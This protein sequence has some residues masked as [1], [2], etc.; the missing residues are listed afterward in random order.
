MFDPQDLHANAA[1]SP[2]RKQ[3]FSSEVKGILRALDLDLI[4]PKRKQIEDLRLHVD[5]AVRASEFLP[6][7]INQEIIELEHQVSS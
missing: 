1:P 6:V 4:S 2:P 3:T 7:C 5:Y